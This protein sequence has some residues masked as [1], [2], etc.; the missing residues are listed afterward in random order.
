MRNLFD[1]RLHQNYRQEHIP[2]LNSLF[3]VI[4]S[5][6]QAGA[7]GAFLSGSGSTVMALTRSNRENV[8]HA[9]RTA[10]SRSNMESEARY[11]KGDNQGLRI[12]PMD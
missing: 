3:E 10:F 9:M 4:S 8:A 1:D 2:A 6:V 12:T 5:A 11:L 7:I